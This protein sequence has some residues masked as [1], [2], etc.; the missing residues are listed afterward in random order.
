MKDKTNNR[1]ALGTVFFMAGLCFSTFASRIPTIRAQFNLNEAQLGTL[2]LVVPIGSIVG[3]PVS[4]WLLEKYDTRIPV[5]RSALFVYF[6]IAA[7]SWTSNI[8]LLATVLFCFSFFN[9]IMIVSM[10]TQA[11]SVQHNFTKKITGSFHGLWSLGGIVGVSI[12]T[13]M[14]TKEI[15]FLWHLISVSILCLVLIS[16][17]KFWLIRD[18]RLK[19]KTNVR[20]CF[21]EKK[22]LLLGT[23]ILLASICEGS[24]FNWSGVYFKDVIGEEI[25]TAGYLAFLIAMTMG[26]FISDLMID[27][28][29]MKRLYLMSALL[30]MSGFILG[31][32]WPYYQLA[33]LGFVLVG[34]GTASMVP[35]TLSL[36]ATLKKYSPGIAISLV[37]TYGMIGLL[38]GPP[39]IG[40]VAHGFGLKTSFLI[41][42]FTALLIIPI[43]R[44]FMKCS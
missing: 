27:W 40:Y 36:A 8:Y 5:I 13:L 16:I 17:V 2:L 19:S 6:F 18:D 23:L 14:I 34:F 43:S 21:P 32:V 3:L 41:L 39:L 42:G 33:L 22:I 28:L 44:I 1:V 9:R 37:T 10:N 4:A 24:M 11:L 29:G 30:T 26:R 7:T 31:V 20:L 25:F 12:S 35:M 38:A 15:G